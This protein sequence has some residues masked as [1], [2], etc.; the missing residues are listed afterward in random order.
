MLPLASHPW[1]L[2]ILYQFMQNSETNTQNATIIHQFFQL[3]EAM[4]E[5]AM[6]CIVVLHT[7][8]ESQSSM[9]YIVNVWLASA[10]CIRRLVVKMD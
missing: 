9:V 2:S 6:H 5:M 4:I 3:E 8:L 7:Y 1:L 10:S